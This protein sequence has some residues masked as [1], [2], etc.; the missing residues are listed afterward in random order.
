MFGKFRQRVQFCLCLSLCLA[1]TEPWQAAALSAPATRSGTEQQTQADDSQ[2]L[3]QKQTLQQEDA[4]LCLY[5]NAEAFPKEARFELEAREADGKLT[6]LLQ[7]QLEKEENGLP[8]GTQTE[9]R[10]YLLQL[11]VNG[12]TQQPQRKADMKL[13]A[14]LDELVKKARLFLASPDGEH[15]EWLA[16]TDKEPI[17]D[18]EGRIRASF[19]T[20]RTGLLVLVLVPDEDKEAASSGTSKAPDEETGSPAKTEAAEE[21]AGSAAQETPQDVQQE[22]SVQKE[23]DSSKDSLEETCTLV[24]EQKAAGNMA[25]PGRAVP[26]TVSWTDPEGEPSG[27]REVELP[28]GEQASLDV[29]KGARVQIEQPDLVSLEGYEEP[30]S[31]QIQFEKTDAGYAASLVMDQD[32]NVVVE[33]RREQV[34]PTG[35]QQDASPA[36]MMLAAAGLLLGTFWIFASFREGHRDRY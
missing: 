25:D 24:L 6:R 4:E 27:K 13:E 35:L 19:E 8:A 20:D 15:L 28:G 1:M 17:V 29:P 31:P 16:G 5:W 11:T 9:I 36:S 22:Q 26:Y 2:T 32:R 23:T 21:P 18:E 33:N 3:W 12:E 34:I 7:A 14:T 30:V 10:M